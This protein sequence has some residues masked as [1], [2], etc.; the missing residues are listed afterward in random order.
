MTHEQ[1][2]DG[3][4]QALASTP[5]VITE[6]MPPLGNMVFVGSGDSLASA[7]ES[8]RAGHRAMSS[9]DIAWTGTVPPSCDTVV[10]I[11]HSGTSGA[12]VRALRIARKAGLR[13][14]AITSRTD[15]PLAAAA[16]HL[17]PVPGLECNEV[18][19]VTGHLMLAQGVA[20][21]SGFDT[22]L[23]NR[24][25]ATA[26]ADVEALIDNVA[27]QLPGHAPDGMSILS[28]PGLRGAADF[29]S[30]KFIEATGLS[31]RNVPLEESGHVDY[32][33]GPQSHLTLLYEG[34]E[35]DFRFA[36]LAEAL[37]ATGQTV[38]RIA[39][40]T[41]TEAK[42]EMLTRSLATAVFSSWLAYHASV[43]WQRPWFRGG[44]VNM[45]ASHIKLPEHV[46]Q[47]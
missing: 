6:P 8:S 14:V 35:A 34:G 18:I 26:L 12:T 31:V 21:V 30:L 15:S 33:I 41:V 4:R 28:L 36:R 11:S 24:D 47:A 2:F 9:G 32:F 40:P 20:A 5:P 42:D 7:L 46:L 45:D 1:D 39:A 17:Q 23:T 38:L 10:G 19:P 13:T 43:R 27:A 25:L 3:L 16:D 44:Q 37:A 29:A 22:S